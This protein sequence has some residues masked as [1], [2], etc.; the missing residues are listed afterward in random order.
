MKNVDIQLVNLSYFP[1][2]IRDLGLSL[3]LNDLIVRQV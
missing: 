1:L 2:R 3:R